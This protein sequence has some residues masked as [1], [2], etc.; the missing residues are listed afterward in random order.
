MAL[1]QVQGG[2]L[3]GSTNT[4]TTI[5]SNGTTAI[6]IDS[7]QKVG[8]GTASPTG[9]LHVYGSG[10]VQTLQRSSGSANNYTL[11]KT[12]T[13]ADQAYLGFSDA[14]VNDFA[15]Y[16]VQ[17]GYIRFGTN[18]AERMRVDSFGSLLVGTT[19]NTYSVAG[20]IYAPDIYNNFNTAAAA[21]MFIEASGFF[22]RSTSS[23]KYKTDVQDAIHG[24]ADVLK[25]RPV[26]YKGINDGETVFGG[27]IAEEVHDAGLN[28]FVQYAPDGSPDALAYGNMVS[29]L[30]KA[31]QE[32]NEKVEA[33]A[34]EIAALKK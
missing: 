31:I 5:Q 21:N 6:T 26:T 17:N 32:L 24:L 2:M 29:L 22:R 18:N 3:A 8:I 25:L 23:I 19:T 4:T 7:S 28:E 16:N 11:F 10:E 30:T 34:A 15:I 9:K 33:Q 20:G 27:L 14:G 1:T 12:Q 13:G